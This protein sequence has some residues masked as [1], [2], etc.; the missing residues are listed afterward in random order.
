[1]VMEFESLGLDTIGIVAGQVWQ[2][3]GANG[4]VTLSKLAKDLD[5]P[6]DTV[7]QG[8]GWLAR[9]GKV[10]FEETPRSKVISLA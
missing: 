5:A 7:M 9:E 3:L 2:Y 1:M 6:R 4:S 8:V 10:R